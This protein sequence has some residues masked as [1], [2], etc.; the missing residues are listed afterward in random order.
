VRVKEPHRFT[1]WLNVGFQHEIANLI[2]TL[3]LKLLEEREAEEVS[4]SAYALQ[5]QDVAREIFLKILRG[6][7]KITNIER[8]EG[9]NLVVSSFTE[10]PSTKCLAY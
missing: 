1:V 6:T 2:P 7:T 9:I 10:N 3:I 4:L 5:D 8:S